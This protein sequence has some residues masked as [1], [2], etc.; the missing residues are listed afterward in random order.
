MINSLLHSILA[1]GVASRK[2]A[3][4]FQHLS[5]VTVPFKLLWPVYKML[6]TLSALAIRRHGLLVA[7]AVTSIT[8]LSISSGPSYSGV[9]TSILDMSIILVSEGMITGVLQTRAVVLVPSS[10][11]VQKEL[12][13]FEALCP[14]SISV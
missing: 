5:V 6:Q 9:R 8:V 11:I 10:Q 12:M 14:A 4:Y 13:L 2:R 3:F 1:H 7:N